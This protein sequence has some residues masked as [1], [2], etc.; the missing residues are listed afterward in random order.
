LVPSRLDEI[1][2]KFEAAE[3]IGRA[4]RPTRYPA[5]REVARIKPKKLGRNDLCLCG[6]MRKWKLCC[7]AQLGD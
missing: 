1:A 6:S 3:S 7:G 5:P 2:A 4:N